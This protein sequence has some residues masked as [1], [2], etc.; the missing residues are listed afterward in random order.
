M[1]VTRSTPDAARGRDGSAGPSG[2][3]CGRV[4]ASAMDVDATNFESASRQS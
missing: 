1:W 3:R 2:L 4:D